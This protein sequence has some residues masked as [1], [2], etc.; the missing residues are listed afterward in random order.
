MLALIWDLV[1]VQ[2]IASCGGDIKPLALSPPSFFQGDVR[3]PKLLF[4]R[5]GE[6]SALVWSTFHTHASFI[7]WP[8]SGEL[9]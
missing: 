3:E 2:M 8:S 6:V 4:E 5:I 7:S 1:S 9:Q